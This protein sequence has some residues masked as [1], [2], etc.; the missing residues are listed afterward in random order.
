MK[1]MPPHQ[2]DLLKLRSSELTPPQRARALELLRVLLK[3]AMSATEGRSQNHD[4]QE[5]S[6]ER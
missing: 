5:A 2:P 1:W 4:T 3:E 6:D